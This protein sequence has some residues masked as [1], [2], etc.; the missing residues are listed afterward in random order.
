MKGAARRSVA[1][2]AVLAALAGILVM[3]AVLQY[4]WISQVSEADRERIQTS[5]ENSVRQ[6]RQEFNRE[7]LNLCLASEPRPGQG[8]DQDGSH[9]AERLENWLQVSPYP[10]IVSQVYLWETEQNKEPSRTLRLDR[11]TH[12]FEPA[13]LP[14]GWGD[15]RERI[16][17]RQKLRRRGGFGEGRVFVWTVVEGQP[18][19]LHPMFVFTRRGDDRRPFPELNG[20]LM[21]ELDR[22]VLGNA[23]LPELA[24]RYF[25]GPDGLDYQVAVLDEGTANEPVYRS[26]ADL[27]AASFLAADLR[28]NLLW[29]PRDYL[30]AAD[31]DG[32]P[33]APQPPPRDRF[34]PRGRPFEKGPPQGGFRGRSPV[35]LLALDESGWQL[36]VKHREGSLDSAVAGLRR[37]NLAVSFG[38]LVLLAASVGMIF[39]SAHRARRL[40]DLQMEFVAGVSHELRTPL[41]VIRSAADNLADGVVHSGPKVKEYGKLIGTE[42]RRLSTMIEQTLQFAGAQTGVKAYDLSSVSVEAV[43][44]RTLNDLKAAVEEAGFQ[45]EASIEP[46]LPAVRSNEDALSRVL[47][48]L[49]QNALKYGGEAKW[50]AVRAAASHANGAREIELQVEDRGPGIDAEDLP[51]VFEPFYRGKLALSNQIQGSGLGLNLAQRISQAVGARLTVESRPGSGSAF[52]MHLPV[53]S[54]ASDKNGSGSIESSR[55]VG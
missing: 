41:A 31:G 51:H 22:G 35:L 20:Y 28:T 26:A 24:Q 27:S 2:V 5:L 3:L 32:P 33:D 55:T 43:V 37:R 29:D 36:V 19:I 1:P 50:L 14:A 48:N 45:V 16:E 23:F 52:A 8:A 6:F 17:D 30:S 38:I 44:R 25:S 49:V 11:S 54:E 13:A 15:L 39:V 21:I 47:S 9:V 34:A 12:S 4:R 42:G 18:V 53:A 46:G 40:A 10:G 7:L